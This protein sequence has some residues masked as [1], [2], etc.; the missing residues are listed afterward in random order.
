MRSLSLIFRE[1]LLNNWLPVPELI[2]EQFIMTW[3]CVW[4][5]H[6][7][8]NQRACFSNLEFSFYLHW[9]FKWLPCSYFHFFSTLA[10]FCWF[11][12]ILSYFRWVSGSF[13]RKSRDSW[14]WIKD[15]LWGECHY[16]DDIIKAVI[17][18]QF[19]C[20]LELHTPSKVVTQWVNCVSY[21][22]VQP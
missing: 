7:L 1:K 15:M 12:L 11:V 4:H 16:F 21:R 6:H 20:S 22:P 9:H 18:F 2:W 13:E 10:L 8:C 5:L 14:Q 3:F 19:T 17:K